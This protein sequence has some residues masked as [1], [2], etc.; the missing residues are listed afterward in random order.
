MFSNRVNHYELDTM[1]GRG[2]PEIDILL[3]NCAYEFIQILL[4]SIDHANHGVDVGD[5]TVW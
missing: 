4:V 1:I 5:S 2:A 3:V